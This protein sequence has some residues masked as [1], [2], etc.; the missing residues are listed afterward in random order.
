MKFSILFLAPLGV[1]ASTL[2]KRFDTV[3]FAPGNGNTTYSK[4]NGHNFRRTTSP[5]D[6]NVNFTG[7]L[8]LRDQAR[9]TKGEWIVKTTS[10]PNDPNDWVILTKND[11]CGLLIKNRSPTEVGN[12][13]VYK[14]L[15]EIYEQDG[16]R[17]D[18]FQETGNFTGCQ[19]GIDVEFWMRRA[20]NLV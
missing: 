16:V 7:C 8:N 10:D 20:N 4:C 1:V 11:V 5:A 17:L 3:P 12:D 14:L 9:D 2:V 19:G 13:D 15:E 6:Q 18:T